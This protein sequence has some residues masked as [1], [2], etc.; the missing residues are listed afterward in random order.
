MFCIF[1]MRD[2]AIDKFPDTNGKQ[3]VEFPHITPC[4]YLN[5]S[6]LFF[7]F[8]KD[9]NT[10]ALILQCATKTIGP[11]YTNFQASCNLPCLYI[12]V[13]FRSGQT[14]QIH[15][16]SLGLNNDLFSSMHKRRR[17]S[18]AQLPRS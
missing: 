16:F 13:C 17:I 5:Y 4:F 9:L 1:L 18:A 8:C 12:L 7:T 10:V 15:A 6:V 11:S 2:G 3:S 14:P